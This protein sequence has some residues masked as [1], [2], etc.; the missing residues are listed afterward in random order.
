MMLLAIMI[1]PIDLVF[2]RLKDSCTNT[3]QQLL[4]GLVILGIYV[5]AIMLGSY[6]GFLF[7][8]LSRYNSVVE[9]TN[10]IIREFPQYSYT[11]VAQQHE[12]KCKQNDRRISA[13][14]SV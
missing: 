11:I 4:S 5:G 9:V 7:Y 12:Y 8:E 14:E 3:V 6:R 2:Y 10:S 13:A 1:M